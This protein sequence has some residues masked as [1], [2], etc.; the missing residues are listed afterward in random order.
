M[1]DL[2]LS[3]HDVSLFSF[4]ILLSPSLSLHAD[5]ASQY[6]QT[7]YLRCS[8][9]G[10]PQLTTAQKGSRRARSASRCTRSAS[11]RPPRRS[12]TCRRSS[13]R[14]RRSS[15][16]RSRRRWSRTRSRA[17]ARASGSTTRRRSGSPSSG[18]DRGLC[19]FL[20]LVLS[21]CPDLSA[22]LRFRCPATHS[23]PTPWTAQPCGG[24]HRRAAHRHYT[25]HR[26]IH[27]IS[28]SC[29]LPTH[30]PSPSY[31]DYL[32]GAPHHPP[33]S[34]VHP[35]Y[36][37]ARVVLTDAHLNDACRLLRHGVVLPTSN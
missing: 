36:S 14:S 21:R 32:L 27:A 35:L 3:L 33:F 4:P 37:Y 17:T 16:S 1:L 30:L 19:L 7:L 8:I 34:V 28:P 15:T 10:A 23:R 6:T 13:R 5:A 2:T 12:G 31:S 18:P 24:P 20:L 26:T 25:A 22:T 9:R 11:G 29:P